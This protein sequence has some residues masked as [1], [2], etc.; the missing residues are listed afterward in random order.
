MLFFQEILRCFRSPYHNAD[1]G[2]SRSANGA[3]EIRAGGDTSAKALKEQSYK[4]SKRH[5]EQQPPPTRP[6]QPGGPAPPGRPRL[7][8]S[9]FGSMIRKGRQNWEENPPSSLCGSADCEPWGQPGALPGHPAGFRAPP[10]KLLADL[11]EISPSSNQCDR[12]KG[13]FRDELLSHL[14]ISLSPTEGARG[15]VLRAIT[16]ALVRTEKRPVFLAFVI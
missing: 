16:E 6:L 15:S 13:I 1:Q 2:P 4:F 5:L 9:A 10:E 7:H 12:A 14:P 3:S 8:A 11:P